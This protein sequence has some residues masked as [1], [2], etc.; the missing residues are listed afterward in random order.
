M[1]AK[2]ITDIQLIQVAGV[3]SKGNSHIS[4]I[5]KNNQGEILFILL[6][7][8]LCLIMVTSVYICFDEK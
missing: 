4:A 5:T 1:T 8:F 7:P 3:M 6:P 2:A